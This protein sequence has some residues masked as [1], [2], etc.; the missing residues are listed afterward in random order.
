MFHVL[1]SVGEEVIKTIATT[2][3]AREQ[4]RSHDVCLN[5]HKIFEQFR[6]RTGWNHDLLVIYANKN[7]VNT[8]RQAGVDFRMS[9]GSLVVQINL[10]PYLRDSSFFS[11]VE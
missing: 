10:P 3:V 9:E 5:P 2:L 6:L 8:H 11:V 4:Q 1:L 7:L